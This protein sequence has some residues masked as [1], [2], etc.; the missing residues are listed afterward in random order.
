MKDKLLRL[1]FTAV[2]FVV[3][4]ALIDLF[5]RN[6]LS[7]FTDL[8]AVA[9]WLITLVVSIGMADYTVKKLK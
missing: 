5:F 8:L 9:C 2:Y 7:V 4:L 6:T 3:F 1:F